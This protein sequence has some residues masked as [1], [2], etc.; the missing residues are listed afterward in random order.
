VIHAVA[1]LVAGTM[2]M[3]FRR[4]FGRSLLGTV[5][6]SM[7]FAGVG[8]AIGA[9]FDRYGQLLVLALIVAGGVLGL[10]PLLGRRKEDAG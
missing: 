7:G 9:S 10:L 2:R 4:F 8:A 1:P 3:P 5:V 6:W